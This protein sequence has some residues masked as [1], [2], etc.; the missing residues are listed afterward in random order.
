MPKIDRRSWNSR[1]K[2]ILNPKPKP[3]RKKK[4]RRPPRPKKPRFPKV[5]LVDNPVSITI[6]DWNFVDGSTNSYT[7]YLEPNISKTLWIDGVTTPGFATLKKK[8]LPLNNYHKHVMTV[9]STAYFYEVK[10]YYG[11]SATTITSASCYN[12]DTFIPI[13]YRGLTNTEHDSK[14]KAR[15]RLA[16]MIAEFPINLGVA[17]AERRQTASLIAA[18]AYR[19]A[20]AAAAVKK[21]DLRNAYGLLG[22]TTPPTDKQLKKI[23]DTPIS[24]RLS[25]YWLELQFGWKPLLEDVKGAAELLASHATGHPYHTEAHGSATARQTAT[26]RRNPYPFKGWIYSKS[27]TRYVLRYRLDDYARAALAST[28]IS[29]PT[30]VLWEILPYSF[31]IDWFLPVGEYLQKLYAFDGF[32]VVAGTQSSIWNGEV[33]KSFERTIT[34][35][36]R[37]SEL[38][39]SKFEEFR[40]DRTGLTDFP[41]SAFPRFRNPLEKGPLWKFITSMALLRTAFSPKI[42]VRF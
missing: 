33:S 27:R 20:H 31:V 5:E 8:Q 15:S 30:T 14:V 12:R 10:D 13:E 17:M 16:K 29:N 38:G 2:S 40:Y 36:V 35:T 41:P 25:Q 7:S 18:T 42:G 34:G 3:P 6:R 21:G 9:K 37:G 32:S 24:K 26:I 28:G 23:I 39:T 19:I 1:Y 4:T 11:G 22:M